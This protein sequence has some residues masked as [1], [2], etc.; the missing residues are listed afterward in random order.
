MSKGLPVPNGIAR[1]FSLRTQSSVGHMGSRKRPKPNPKADVESQLPAQ[2]D[3]PK[4]EGEALPCDAL[5]SAVRSEK[6]QAIE[7]ASSSNVG[8]TT[9]ST[10]GHNNHYT[11]Y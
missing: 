2:P 10:A 11:V 3:T 8:T 4:P 5:E 7:A 1:V 6:S 9:V